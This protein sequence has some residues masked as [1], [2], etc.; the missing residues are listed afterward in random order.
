MAFVAW[1]TRPGGRW[2]GGSIGGGL[3]QPC[4]KEGFR[5]V[6]LQ[7]GECT[8]QQVKWCQ[9]AGLFVAVWNVVDANLGDALDE[10]QPDGVMPQIEGDGQYDGAIA[11]LNAIR[12]R[13]LPRAIVTT[14]G[15]LTN[16]GSVT[17]G[18]R[19]AALRNLGVRGCFVECYA[20]DDPVH[21]NLDRMLAQGVVY[22]VPA[23]D[24]SPVCGTFRGEMP[25]AYEG[26]TKHGRDFSVYLAE[27]MN[28]AQWDAWGALPPVVPPKPKLAYWQVTAGA[29]LLHEE[30][31]KTYPDGSTGLAK[32]ITWMQAHPDR[33]RT[34]K[35]VTLAR[36]LR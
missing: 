6:A 1:E 34:A 13:D 3:I 25:T 35:A 4:L 31:A 22:G 16:P 19:Y 7:I 33:I 21:A 8:R 12:A 36:V 5:T 10:L 15:G 27:T 24:L 26:L 32:A 9:D 18:K 29:A 23:G 2:E 20:S 17:D 11:G 30:E 14:Y 28:T